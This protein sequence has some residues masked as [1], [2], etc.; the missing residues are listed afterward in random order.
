MK[1]LILILLVTLVLLPASAAAQTPQ[2]SEKFSGYAIRFQIRDDLNSFYPIPGSGI[3]VGFTV[4]TVQSAD[5]P[6]RTLVSMINL[7]AE[8]RDDQWD[9]SVSV[10][11]PKGERK[12]LAAG[13][14]SA[15]QKI[16]VEKF[17]DYDLRASEVTIVKIDPVSAIEPE[18][19][20]R[21]SSIEV[22]SIKVTVIPMRFQLVLR[23]NSD[24]PVRGLELNTYKGVN[25]HSLAW[26]EGNVDRFLIP[27]GETHK[28]DLPS[29][30]GYKLVA[31]DEYEP[32][33]TDR[34]EIATVVF[35]DGSYEGKPHLARLIAA[36]S[37]GATV[38]L[39]R[40]LPLI[41][42][43]LDSTGVDK[44]ELVTN[45]KE[46]VS[47]LDV[48]VQPAYADQ[49]RMQFSTLDEDELKGYYGSIVLGLE[50]VKGG[51]LGDL[52]KFTK[53]LEKDPNASVRGWLAKEQERYEK[54]RAQLP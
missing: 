6:S 46:A 54:W 16:N 23:N 39:D 21:T 26:P 5:T 9:L 37:I 35:A 49:L 10:T 12:V 50:Q 4:S 31:P 32:S 24:R 51:M 40:V 8:R 43:A 52:N 36:K 7:S 33:Q 19:I 38:Q 18:I 1:N 28:F 27:P 2:T 3:N 34:V 15:G 42:T 48:G 13:R 47:A 44:A 11:L 53:D 17:R 22:S 20:N 29:A 25:Q 30:A 14:V 45:L 41:A